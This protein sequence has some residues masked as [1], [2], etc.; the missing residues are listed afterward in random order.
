MSTGNATAVLDLLN[1]FYPLNNLYAVRFFMA[2][3]ISKKKRCNQY[4]VE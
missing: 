1:Y 4:Y 3:D 2:G